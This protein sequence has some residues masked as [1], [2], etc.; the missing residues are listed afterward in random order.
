MAAGSKPI[1]NIE[2]I[3][4]TISLNCLKILYQ[5][6]FLTAESK[7]NVREDGMFW[8]TEELTWKVGLNL[9]EEES[10]DEVPQRLL[11]PVL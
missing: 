4:D 9:Q 2:K 11:K 10:I 7:W 1:L 8:D 5:G 6:L 3:I